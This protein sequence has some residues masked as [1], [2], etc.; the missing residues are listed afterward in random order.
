MSSCCLDELYGEQCID[1]WTYPGPWLFLTMVLT[2]FVC[3]A[4]LE[5]MERQLGMAP[6]IVTVEQIADHARNDSTNPVGKFI[7]NKRLTKSYFGGYRMQTRGTIYYIRFIWSGGI[8]FIGTG[9]YLANIE[10]F[11]D[12][13]VRLKPES[14]YFPPYQ[15]VNACIIAFYLWE[16]AANRYGKI[17]WSIIVHH[18]LTIAAAMQILFG[19]YSPFATWYGFT[20]IAM[21]FPV[22]LS[23]AVRAT[24]SNRYPEQTRLAFTISFYWWSFCLLLNLSGQIFIITNALLPRNFNGPIPVYNVVLMVFAMLGWVYDDY[25]VLAT[26][27]DFA[28]HDYADAEILEKKETSRTRAAVYGRTLLAQAIIDDIM[29]EKNNNVKRKP[30][31]RA[32]GTETKVL[33]MVNLQAVHV[34]DGQTPDSD[35]KQQTP[36]TPESRDTAK[37]DVAAEEIITTALDRQMPL[38]P[39]DNLSTMLERIPT[40]KVDDLDALVEALSIAK[41]ELSRLKKVAANESEQ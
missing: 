23:L 14:T 26:L 40:M 36:M 22:D 30:S 4:L 12:H 7:V 29:D 34:V 38:S 19:S 28:T 3:W 10:W 31:K 16:L 25:Q 20:I 9:L 27:R 1:E 37:V 6:K 11:L 5:I 21:T 17:T 41:S 2:G 8:F 33:E 32:N 18:W 39:S 35:M 15:H 13:F 24:V